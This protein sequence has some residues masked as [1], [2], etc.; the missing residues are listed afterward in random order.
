MNG[1]RGVRP[2]RYANKPAKKPVGTKPSLRLECE[3]LRGSLEPNGD[4]FNMPSSPNSPYS[5]IQIAWL[6]GKACKTI[7]TGDVLIFI[8]EGGW[9]MMP[10]WSPSSFQGFLTPGGGKAK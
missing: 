6:K 3:Y 5:Y 10:P 8:R 2:L 4:A 7:L 9:T 1:T